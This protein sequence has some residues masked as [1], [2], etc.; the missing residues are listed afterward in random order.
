MN[1]LRPPAFPSRRAARL[2][3]LALTLAAAQGAWAQDDEE[4]VAMVSQPV[5]QPIVASKGMKLNDALGLLARNPQDVSALIGAGRAS[6]E[7]G[8]LDAAV[9]FFQRADR[10]A[11][12]NAQVKAG[13]AGA[14]AQ[15]EDPF[16]AIPLF[17]EAEKAGAIDPLLQADRGLAYDLVGDNASAQ[18]YYRTALAAGQND[19]VLRRLALS[20]AIAGDRRGM[21]STLSPL[22]QRQDKAA[23]R[24]RAFGLA[25]LGQ[26][27]EGIA[28]A[29]TNLPAAL[30]DSMAGYL[31][32]MPRLTAA[33][34]AAAANLGH[35]PRAS[36]IGRDDPRVV[37][38]QPKRPVLAAASPVPPPSS[39]K[40]K[41]GRDK[42]DRNARP[43][44]QVAA[45][46]PA[47]PP[48]NREVVS[49]P[50]ARAVATPPAAA[51]VKTAVAPPPPAAAPVRVVVTP[52]P[53]SA[54]VKVAVAAPPP[55]PAPAVPL[56]ASSPPVQVAVATPPA[57]APGFATL[58]SAAAPIA[59]GFDLKP[60]VSAPLPP[61]PPPPPPPPAAAPAPVK[62]RSL[63]EVFADLTP[64]SR[65]AVPTAGAVD[66][67]RIGPARPLAAKDGKDGKVLADAACETDA[68]PAK[69]VR[70]IKGGKAARPAAK[71]EQCEVDPRGKAK[72]P[73]A[74]Q[75]SRVWVQ[76]ATGKD[77]S[78]LGFDWRRM[79][80]ENAE[81][82]GKYKPAISAWGQ[83]NRLLAGPF[84]S[85]SA[86][87]AVV[88]RLKKAGVGGAFVW[89]SPAG[90]VVDPIGGGK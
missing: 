8:D 63:A 38:F 50:V 33:Q 67:R 41:K 31:Q 22:L 11:P 5:V 82:L 51:P 88:S 37:L 28:I 36:E 34:Q 29:R 65:E 17:S 25:I 48:V 6:M 49:A 1:L 7:I 45:A 85:E 59:P 58:E 15:S 90:Q 39:G 68:K 53:A 52:P 55:P 83:S 10:L 30:A 27:E 62:Q 66:V 77:K 89:T 13:L 76:L 35:F 69:G 70:V 54:P 81:I 87:S 44:V 26:P 56:P 18:R 2:A 86:A 42:P 71:A 60:A 80:K 32:Y 3:V 21:E 14:Y 47:L 75:P 72:S 64:P 61:P 24:T 84:E 16:T 79:V 9:G 46:A 4:E 12:G 40:G 73:A 20:Q 23:W 19:E 43:P 74:S 57:S 78:A